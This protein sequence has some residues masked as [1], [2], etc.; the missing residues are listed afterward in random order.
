[1]FRQVGAGYRIEACSNAMNWSPVSPSRRCRLKGTGSRNREPLVNISSL[2]IRVWMLALAATCLIAG[3]RGGRPERAAALACV[4]A[5]LATL[6]YLH[7]RSWDQPLWW[8]F[9]V[10]L[11]LL[12]VL[13]GLT[14]VFD[15][16]W[17]LFASAFQLLGVTIHFATAA[18]SL[19]RP[20]TYA[21]GLVAWNYLVLVAIAFGSWTARRADDPAT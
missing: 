20:L 14:L 10:D 3:L 17:L 18:D 11:V 5:W 7:N 12:V 8:L 4:V 13:I 9:G 2:P 21:R 15:R 16:R 19:I 1:M 6:T